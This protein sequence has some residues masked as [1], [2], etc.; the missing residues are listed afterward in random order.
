MKIA[1]ARNEL[2][3]DAGGRFVSTLVIDV[4]SSVAEAV[5]SSSAMPAKC[6]AT[7]SAPTMAFRTQ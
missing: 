3:V 2:M 1:G 7:V 6:I 4:Q 5:K